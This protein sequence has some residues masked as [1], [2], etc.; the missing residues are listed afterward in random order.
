MKL[1]GLTE[2]CWILN[3]RKFGTDCLE[4]SRPRGYVVYSLPVKLEML[5]IMV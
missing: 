1:I 5:N 2:S 3:D 4:S